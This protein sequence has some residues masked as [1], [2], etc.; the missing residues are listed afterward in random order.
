M[1]TAGLF[2]TVTDVTDD[3]IGDPHALTLRMYVNG[4]LRQEVGRGPERHEELAPV[5]V[6][7]GIRHRQYAR[8]I[9]AQDDFTAKAVARP[10]CP[11]P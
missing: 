3:E 10:S 6:R 9:V 8:L 4:E 11:I 5:R 7:P 2:G 1:T